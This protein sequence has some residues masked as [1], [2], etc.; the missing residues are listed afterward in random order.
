MGDQIIMWLLGL[1]GT[2]FVGGAMMWARKIS[3]TLDSINTTLRDSARF[4]GSMDAFAK[5]TLRRFH[6]H[7][8]RFDRLEAAQH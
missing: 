5:D 8:K 7:E 1:G 2:L 4:E 6:D 3:G